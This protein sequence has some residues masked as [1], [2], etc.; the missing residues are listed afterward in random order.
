MP[1]SYTQ[2]YYH[3]VWAT[4]LRQPILDPAMLRTVDRAMREKSGKL[5][6]TIYAVN[7][8]A[9]HVHLAVRLPATLAIADYV[10][11]VKGYASWLVNHSPEHTQTLYWQDGYGAVTFRKSELP[12]VVR[13][14]QRQ[15]EHH[16]Q[17]DLWDEFER[18]E[19]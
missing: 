17:R 1:Q 8:V 10:E 11:Q 13:Y 3:V 7:G 16:Q 14:I 4:K 6:G 12:V 2:L 18:W 9:D 5:R 15:Q 19:G